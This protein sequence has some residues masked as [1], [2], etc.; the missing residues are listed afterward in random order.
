MPKP[1]SNGNINVLF[2][3]NKYGD[4]TEFKAEAN[5]GTVNTNPRANPY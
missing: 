1:N 5:S 2:F 4:K 3:S